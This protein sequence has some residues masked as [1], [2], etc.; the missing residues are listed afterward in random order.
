MKA[1]YVV[2]KRSDD[3]QWF[4][5]VKSANNRTLSVS[6]MYGRRWNAKRAAKKANPGLE[7]RVAT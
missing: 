7:I 2:V 3:G 4:Y 5:L 1:H 6:E